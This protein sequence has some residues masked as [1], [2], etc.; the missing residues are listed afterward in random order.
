MQY[1]GSIGIVQF[2][3]SISIGI[4]Q[5]VDSISIGIVQYV[6]SIRIGIVQYVGSISIGIVQYVDCISIGGPVALWIR[7]NPL[8]CRPPLLK[9]LESKC[10]GFKSRQ[11]PSMGKKYPTS[12]ARDLVLAPK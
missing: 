11:I 5:Y 4:V 6:D 2:V 8:T 3:G 9:P 12:V 1:V 10:P 7:R